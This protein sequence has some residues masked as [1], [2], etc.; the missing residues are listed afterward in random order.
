[1]V[2][3]VEELR[4]ELDGGAFGNGGRFLQREIRVEDARA[5][6]ESPVGITESAQRLRG[7]SARQEIGVR[8]IGAGI[9]RI[10]NLHR[11]YHVRNVNGRA[12]HQRNI[13][14]A[15]TQAD[16]EA[17]VER[18]D[19]HQ[20]PASHQPLRRSAEGSRKGYRPVVAHHEIVPHI[21]R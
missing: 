8:A 6:E 12:A 13:Q 14:S 7:E 5:A 17:V 15:L 19:A 1:M 16:G 11:A 20:V 3:D 10:L 2:E 21:E 4:A 9:V 18:R